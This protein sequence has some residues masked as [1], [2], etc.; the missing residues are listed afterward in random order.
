MSCSSTTDEKFT[1]SSS[2]LSRYQTSFQTPQSK[3]SQS[4]HS[5][6]TSDELLP[7]QHI[8]QNETLSTNL[9]QQQP[10]Q[11]NP[12]INSA[13]QN[14]I[15]LSR[16]KKKMRPEDDILYQ[17][18]LARKMEMAAQAVEKQNPF[19][20]RISYKVSKE[21]SSTSFNNNY[22]REEI[23]EEK[24]FSQV[25]G[26]EGSKQ[27]EKDCSCRKEKRLKERS[28]EEPKQIKTK[29]FSEE[30]ILSR[31]F[32][33]EFL[34]NNQHLKCCQQDFDQRKS[35]CEENRESKH[36]AVQQVST[37]IQ[38]E[39]EDLKISKVSTGVQCDQLVKLNKK[40]TIQSRAAPVI[41]DVRFFY[42]L[43]WNVYKSNN[44]F[45]R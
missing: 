38:V 9:K 14:L 19:L 11:Q 43:K 22:D 41:N 28:P 21:D 20:Q 27:T 37:G 17:W 8:Q 45:F 6:Y 40:E 34:R 26:I 5:Q 23:E 2:T 24:H 33:K 29:D 16:E 25:K 4:K 15:P 44:F 3:H 12:W 32:H 42:S 35:F 7:T 31:Q 13:A 36:S 30:E 18:R 10:I 1:I 39:S